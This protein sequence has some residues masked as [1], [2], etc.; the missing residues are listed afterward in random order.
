MFSSRFYYF[1]EKLYYFS[2][3]LAFFGI[4]STWLNT[5]ERPI[6]GLELIIGFP[7]LIVLI[8]SSILVFLV[9]RRYKPAAIIMIIA[10]LLSFIGVGF[11][12][13]STRSL[14]FGTSALFA[15]VVQYGIGIYMTLLGTFGMIV[16]G[17]VAFVRKGK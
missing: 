8:L 6:I 17:I 15:L 12:Y 16:S 9:G 7:I 10:G 3:G 14:L 2:V 11:F 4:F 1:H 13:L 5:T